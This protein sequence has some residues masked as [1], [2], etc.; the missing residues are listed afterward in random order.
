MSL[1]TFLSVIKKQKKKKKGRCEQILVRVRL[2]TQNIFAVLTWAK[3][4]AFYF[5]HPLFHPPYW[6]KCGKP[7]LHFQVI[8]PRTDFAPFKHFRHLINPRSLPILFVSNI[9]MTHTK[10]Y[11]SVFQRKTKC[12]RRSTTKNSLNYSC[13]CKKVLT[14]LKE[15]LA[16]AVIQ[17]GT[18]QI[19]IQK[20]KSNYSGILA[21]PLTEEYPNS[22]SSNSNLNNLL[23]TGKGPLG[24]QRYT[25]QAS[26]LPQLSWNQRE[27][28]FSSTDC[29]QDTVQSLAVYDVLYL[30]T[31]HR[32]L[33]VTKTPVFS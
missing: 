8:K 25:L 10:S 14:S 26:K 24:S 28:H 23:F 21:V 6:K 19:K 11:M 3:S 5:S 7:M 13:K 33:S 17:T 30:S 15:C 29:V 1:R 20:V 18:W 22:L 31:H 12:T 2:K 27:D 16:G 9:V 32:N 4:V